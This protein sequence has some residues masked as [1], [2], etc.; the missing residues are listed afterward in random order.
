MRI[1]IVT[2]AFSPEAELK[3]FAEGRTEA[4][5]LASFIGYCRAASHG[6]AVERLELEH[7]P[8]FTETEIRGFAAQVLQR[9]AL[10]DVLIVHRVGAIAPGEAI[11]L[12][13]ALSPHRAD[14]FAAVEELMDRL[15]TDAPIWK[16]EWGADGARWIEPT[17][18]D[19]A[20]RAERDTE[21]KTS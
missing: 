8:G 17:N 11:V 1:A 15:K 19:R 16:K 2:E 10:I 20:R 13:A 14:A 9:R 6:R 12:A 5:A 21:D 3:A 4:G 7:Y 18:E